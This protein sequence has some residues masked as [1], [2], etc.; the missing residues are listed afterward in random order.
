[1]DQ[2]NIRRIDGRMNGGDKLFGAMDP[3]KVEER[4]FYFEQI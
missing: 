1:M 2:I 4:Q 3:T